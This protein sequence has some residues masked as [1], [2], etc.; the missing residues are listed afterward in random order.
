MWKTGNLKSLCFLG[1]EVKRKCLVIFFLVKKVIL[2]GENVDLWMVQKL[3]FS[4]AHGFCQQLK[5]SK[6]FL[7]LA[8]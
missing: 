3:R 6:F 5:I 8:N 1:K 7:F 4:K 2:D